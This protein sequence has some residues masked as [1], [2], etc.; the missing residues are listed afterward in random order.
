MG[1]NSLEYIAK[2]TCEGQIF[3]LASAAKGG[4]VHMLYLE[5]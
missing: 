3:D 1:G 2:R 5:V 4:R